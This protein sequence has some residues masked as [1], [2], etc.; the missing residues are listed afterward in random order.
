[1]KFFLIAIVGICLWLSLAQASTDS[2][3]K[4]V[5]YVRSFNDQAI[6]IDN[7]NQRYTVP[8]AH[9]PE[10]TKT[11]ELVSVSVTQEEFAA[12]KHSTSVKQ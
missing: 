10:K 4:L 11:G 2:K 5:G 12:L 7:G 8:R 3:L 9:Y 1:M 6:V